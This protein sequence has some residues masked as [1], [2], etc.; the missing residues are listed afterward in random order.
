M[1]D[2][3]EI[4]V[5]AGQLHLIN[6]G[7]NKADMEA[8]VNAAGYLPSAGLDITILPPDGDQVLPEGEVLIILGNVVTSHVVPA[9]IELDD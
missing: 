3:I 5:Q 2:Y 4:R 8:A 7:S 6:H 9:H 1:P